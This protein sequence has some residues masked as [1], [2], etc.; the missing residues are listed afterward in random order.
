[1]E[2]EIEFKLKKDIKEILLTFFNNY[3]FE[4]CLMVLWEV[5]NAIL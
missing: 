5:S 2:V 1:M 4:K 3:S